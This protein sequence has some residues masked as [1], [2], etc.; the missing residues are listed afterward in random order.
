MD[1]Y[2]T[3]HLA[4]G[5]SLARE[6]LGRI[7]ADSGFVVAQSVSHV[8]DLSA[9]DDM[10]KSIII[11]D[12]SYIENGITDHIV[13]MADRFPATKI[14]ILKES[15][16][17]DLMNQIFAAG[18]HGYVLK[19]IPYQTFVAMIR[20][21]AM[22]ERVAPST[23]IDILQEIQPEKRR[24]AAGAE[25]RGFDL[26]ER[27]QEILNSLVLGFTNKMIA[28]QLDMSEATVKVSV[29]TLFRKLSVKNR[30]Q[31]AVMA[32]QSGLISGGAPSSTDRAPF[33]GKDC[34]PLCN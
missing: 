18:A 13:E 6:G 22:G 14:V 32:R 20:L 21:V 1:P 5:S 34:Q 31:A 27:E 10:E 28:R 11:A 12:Y 17:F 8:D 15:F 16:N 29:K 30:T 19:D 7:L 9:E 25:D 2:S 24:S 4:A 26:N 33:N 3:V 23:L